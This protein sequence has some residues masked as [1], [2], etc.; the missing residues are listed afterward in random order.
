MKL[1]EENGRKG[2]NGFGQYTLVKNM[3]E[4]SNDTGA[5]SRG[6]GIPYDKP[7]DRTA[8]H[9]EYGWHERSHAIATMAIVGIG[10]SYSRDNW[11]AEDCAYEH[12]QL[13]TVSVG[14][15]GRYCCKKD[16][17]MSLMARSS[18]SPEV[19]EG[20]FEAIQNTKKHSQYRSNHMTP[21]P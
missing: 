3:L 9:H 10:Q 6:K 16:L 14:S 15:L 18:T 4:I 2:S 11:L 19:L 1:A 17:M 13:W 21:K 8:S 7:L 20:A 12:E 5:F